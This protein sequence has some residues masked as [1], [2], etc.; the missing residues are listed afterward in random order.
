MAKENKPSIEKVNITKSTNRNLYRVK[1]NQ[2]NI[3]FKKVAWL[4]NMKLL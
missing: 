1:L 4:I 3:L 2:N